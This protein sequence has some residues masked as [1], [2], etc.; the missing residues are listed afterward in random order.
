MVSC[1]AGGA[2]YSLEVLNLSSCSS[3]RDI[4]KPGPERYFESLRG[5]IMINTEVTSWESI[6]NLERWTNGALQSLRIS[7][8]GVEDDGLD[9]LLDPTRMTGK[10]KLDR[11]VLIAKLSGLVTLNSTPITPAERRDAEMH[12]VKYVSGLPENTKEGWGRYE[13]L[14]GMYTV[15]EKPVATSLRSK[16]ISEWSSRRADFSITCVSSTIRPV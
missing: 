5:V 2:D 1:P 3:L 6:D 10:A 15:E 7:L 12:C 13:V 4:P 16:M 11:P 8:A 14:R 9:G